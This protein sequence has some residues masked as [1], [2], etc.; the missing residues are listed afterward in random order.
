MYKGIYGFSG[1]AG[2]SPYS[3]PLI[4]KLSETLESLILFI[5]YS[6]SSLAF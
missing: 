3:I 1:M 4:H 2:P 6:L 5:S